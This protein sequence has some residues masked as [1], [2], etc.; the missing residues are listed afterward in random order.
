VD[1][2]R[3]PCSSISWILLKEE[4]RLGSKQSL[5][6][7]LHEITGIAIQALQG[8]P[9]FR[10][11]VSE[12]MSWKAK[13]QTKPDE[14]G[15]YPLLGIFDICMPLIYGEGQSGAMIRLQREIQDQTRELLEPLRYDQI[16]ARQIKIENAN[17]K[18]CG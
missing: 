18:T 5:E 10:F 7:T 15:V 4:Q 9:L 2:S 6:Q 14:D 16:D 1:A 12:C 11:S 8:T 17:V 3:A 13:R